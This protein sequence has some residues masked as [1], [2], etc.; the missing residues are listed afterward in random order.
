VLHIGAVYGGPELRGT[1]I[2]LA[3][4]RVCR[5]AAEH[6]IEHS[7]SL[8][9]VFHVPG[10]LWA[11]SYEGARTGRLSRKER[12]VQIQVA[13]PS[14]L[15]SREPEVIMEFIAASLRQAIQIA[16]PRLERAGLTYR[17]DQYE[18]LVGR[19][20]ASLLPN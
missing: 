15:N 7:A 12:I 10:S 1:R 4:T 18:R 14:E 2:D 17:F 20:A 8:D 5:I 13:V 9:V 6:P 16:R 3:L 19:I 11:P